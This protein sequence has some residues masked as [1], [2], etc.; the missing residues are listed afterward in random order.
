M[1]EQII[2]IVAVILVLGWF[3][4]GIVINLRRGNNLLR[5]MQSGL[6][7]VGERTT[8]RWL[9]SSVAEM[10][11]AHAKKPFQQMKVLIVLVPRDVPWMWAWA[12]LRKRQDLVIFR[13]HLATAPRLEFD[14]VNPSTW[15]GRIAQEDALKKGW[16]SSPSAGM[17]LLTP[18]NQQDQTARARPAVEKA[19]QSLS[20]APIRCSVRCEAPHLEVHL[21][22][23]DPRSTEAKEFFHALQ[24]L[25]LVISERANR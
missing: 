15:T 1:S 23:P 18:T 13:S 22:L 6:P 8:L 16:R 17:V 12:S 25:A 9:G 20:V 19:L 3:G 10:V 7:L 4:A 11:I 2:V 24:H 14:L 21:P 5:W